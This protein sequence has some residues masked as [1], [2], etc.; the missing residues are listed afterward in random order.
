VK[1]DRPEWSREESNLQ[2]EVTELRP[3]SPPPAQSPPELRSIEAVD[4]LEVR[5][6][7]S[8]TGDCAGRHRRNNSVLVL[9]SYR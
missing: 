4:E 6:V 1:T 9:D 3:L 7:P 8:S 2:A 5:C